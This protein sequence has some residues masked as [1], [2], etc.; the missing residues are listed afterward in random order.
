MK[1]LTYIGTLSRPTNPSAIP[2]VFLR[3]PAPASRSQLACAAK[4]FA[5]R[6][7]A[8]IEQ[9]ARPGGYSAITPARA[10]YFPSRRNSPMR[11][12]TSGGGSH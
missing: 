10:L 2:F 4:P 8:S 5:N 12:R 9:P 7:G 11:R 6:F 3:G 1:G